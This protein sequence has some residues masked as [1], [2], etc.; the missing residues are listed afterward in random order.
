MSTNNRLTGTG[1]NN[2]SD[3]NE[4]GE[5][6]QASDLFKSFVAN[7]S[8]E[9]VAE[10]AEEARK[11]VN[12]S[13]EDR[14][15]LDEYQSRL[16][17]RSTLPAAGETT[18]ISGNTSD[19]THQTL[20]LSAIGGPEV[21]APVSPARN[22]SSTTVMIDL[23]EAMPSSGRTSR[24]DG[25]TF[26]T[27]RG[28]SIGFEGVSRESIEG[29]GLESIEEQFFLNPVVKENE[30]VDQYI[31]ATPKGKLKAK[32]AELAS[33]AEGAVEAIGSN[34]KRFAVK[35]PLLRFANNSWKAVKATAGAARSAF[36]TMFF[37]EEINILGSQVS[38]KEAALNKA[39]EEYRHDIRT[40]GKSFNALDEYIDSLDPMTLEFVAQSD[41]AVIDFLY[42]CRFNKD[43]EHY[44]AVK[45][46][47]EAKLAKRQGEFN[48]QIKSIKESTEIDF[49]GYFG[50]KQKKDNKAKVEQNSQSAE[51][52]A[53]REKLVNDLFSNETEINIR[54]EHLIAFMEHYGVYKV[55]CQMVI[56]SLRGSEIDAENLAITKDVFAKTLEKLDIMKAQSA[57][58]NAEAIKQAEEEAEAITD[59]QTTF[60]YSENKAKKILAKNKALKEAE[61]AKEQREKEFSE[62]GQMEP[63]SGF[64]RL[65]MRAYFGIRKVMD[66]IIEGKE[67]K[68]EAY[69]LENIKLSDEIG[70]RFDKNDYSADFYPVTEEKEKDRSFTE[71][72]GKWVFAAAAMIT[73]LGVGNVFKKKYDANKAANG[74]F[75]AVGSS[76][77]TKVETSVPSASSSAS[78]VETAPIASA[79]TAP[80][81]ATP[82]NSSVIDSMGSKP[83]M[84]ASKG[85]D[86]QSSAKAPEKAKSVVVEK[87]KQTELPKVE[88][89]VKP[90]KTTT[91][92]PV[93]K[94]TPGEKVPVAKGKSDKTVDKSGKTDKKTD[95]PVENTDEK[96]L[97]ES[98]KTDV[99]IQAR[100]KLE[101]YNTRFEKA[102]ADIKIPQDIA[103][104]PIAYKQPNTERY[105]AS[106]DGLK[107]VAGE[108]K[109]KGDLKKVQAAHNEVNSA[110]GEIEA[111]RKAQVV[112][113]YNDIAKNYS[114]FAA[115][116][117][118]SAYAYLKGKPSKFT[119]TH[120]MYSESANKTEIKT[121]IDYKID[122]EA[123]SAELARIENESKDPNISEA[124]ALHNLRVA[125][126][127]EKTLN[128]INHHLYRE[129]LGQHKAAFSFNR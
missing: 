47:T 94:K 82:V 86:K 107:K 117:V 125:I 24:F 20:G 79:S 33:Y 123:I 114:I 77:S 37:P 90:P 62:R 44:D 25:A 81:V 63:L 99:V 118:K 40:L 95:K 108:I 84:M 4:K 64:A 116:R 122:L 5:M 112:R 85:M 34:E 115:G 12:K 55:A 3:I 87:P 1:I 35:N 124:K 65:R 71:K 128:F 83:G 78:A 48:A 104:A 2:S 59:L 36:N 49:E 42:D 39:L 76:S 32:A 10:K 60:G 51:D 121:M 75:S 30:L 129:R 43:S 26:T 73:A 105:I 98:E 9:W 8:D 109:V 110:L 6:Q 45:T 56:Q 28:E 70:V 74:D 97:T 19:R 14:A 38:K 23:N 102:T 113:Y 53:F 22:S 127:W 29:L 92:K 50:V 93:A 41:Q 103:Y 13:P 69:L 100:I 46:I 111:G 21:E 101:A 27:R 72:Y 17:A 106:L 91:E 126:Y 61:K 57:E 96:I 7:R 88:V 66:R 52:K 31:L 68:A 11:K 54:T 18:E 58:A 16:A 119:Y 67:A 89:P 15:I 120:N 80:I